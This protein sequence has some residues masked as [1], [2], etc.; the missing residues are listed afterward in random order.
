[1]NRPH[2]L[3]DRFEIS[4]GVLERIR[5]DHDRFL[6][7][8]P[9]DLH[10]Y[11]L[12]RYGFDV[13]GRYAGCRIEVPFGKASGQLS[14][15]L[16]QVRADA[17]AGLGFV[18]LKTVIAED[19]RGCRTMD[20]WAVAESRMRV[21]RITG[22]GGER[23]WT[24]T[25]KGRGWPGSL[26]DYLVLVEAAAAVGREAGMPVAA[27]CKFHLPASGEA[28]NVQ[29]YSHTLS[30]LVAAWRRVEPDAPFILEKDF[31]PTLAGT[32]A[33]ARRRTVLRW[34]GEVAGVIKAHPGIVLGIKV[35]NA[36]F[37]DAF[38][39][40][41]V[42]A[43]LEAEVRPDFLVYANRLFDPD[44]THEGQKGIAYGGPDLSDRNLRTLSRI[45][46]LEARGDLPPL[47]P[48]SATGNVCSGRMAL[49]YVLRGC[50]SLQLHTFFQVPASEYAMAQGSR[51]ARALH[52]LLFSPDS[53]LIAGLHHCRQRWPYLFPGKGASVLDL[54]SA[55]RDERF[56]REVIDP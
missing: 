9:P 3:P 53:G 35:M 30:R 10:A 29:E 28:W 52:H 5:E 43:L 55:W 6:R 11:V 36:V 14:M 44:R 24:V 26:E 54:T 42:R 16:D 12:D 47:P 13:S 56:R 23:G 4:L 19:A 37:D 2:W 41:M 34:L 48:V 17:A 49:E 46:H 18:V 50:T 31:S 32:D 21:E 7:D 20:A 33:A 39:V 1:M 51:S 40:D 38:Q 22:R 45:R 8:L 25:W 15:T 27:S